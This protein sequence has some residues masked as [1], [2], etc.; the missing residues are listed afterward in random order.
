[1]IKLFI[2]VL[3]IV[4]VSY[5]CKMQWQYGENSSGCVIVDG[6]KREFRY[7]MP[8]HAK[9]VHLP[10]VLAFHGGGGNPKRFEKYSRFSE[11]SEKSASFIVVYP[12]GIDKYWNDGRINVNNKVDDVSFLKRLI[13]IMPQVDEEEVYVVGMS[14]GGL[15]A[16]RMACEASDKLKGIA[17]VGATM[18]NEL[19]YNCRDNKPLKSLFIYGDKDSAFLVNGDLVNPL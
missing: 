5:G 19:I 2:S 7:F 10:L 18:S 1:M 9:G 6:E 16:Q 8:E 11:L 13:H 14:N 4:S 3:L 12:E 17:V 15:M